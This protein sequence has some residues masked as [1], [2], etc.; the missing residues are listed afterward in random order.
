MDCTPTGVYRDGRI[1]IERRL[2]LT[3]DDAWNAL[4]AS[5]HT[6]LWIG[7]WSGDPASG[8]ITLTMTAEEGSP[9]MPLQVIECEAPERA[10]V[11]TGEG[12]DVWTLYGEV[13]PAHADEGGAVVALAQVIDDPEKASAVGP[14][15]EYYLDRLVAAETGGDPEAIDFDDYYPSMADY[16]RALLG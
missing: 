16:Y 13:R 1:V 15:W 3:V 5:E 11:R 6:A 4:T 10:A 14:G 7:P 12:D 2:A 9:A 8:H